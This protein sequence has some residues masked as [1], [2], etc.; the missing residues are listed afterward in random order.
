MKKKG[1]QEGGERASENERNMVK[2][3]RVSENESQREGA[4]GGTG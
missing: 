2:Q 3:A 1:E 4:E